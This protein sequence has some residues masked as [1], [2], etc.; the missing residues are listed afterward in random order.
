MHDVENRELGNMYKIKNEDDHDELPL[1]MANQLDTESNDTLS[2][3]ILLVLYILQGIPMGLA[4]S[5]PLLLKEKGASYES[6]SLFSL[7]SMP[8]S[9]KLVWA[10]IV[11]ST[12]LT[13][14]GRRKTW[15]IPVQLICGLIMIFGASHIDEWIGDNKSNHTGSMLNVELLTMFFMFLYFLMAT[16]DIAVDGWALT[17]LSRRNVGYGSVCNTIGQSLGAFI[18][19]QGFIALSDE[20]WCHRFLGV[21]QGTTFVTLS[22]F[23]K[24]WGIVFLVTTLVIWFF[25]SESPI[26]AGDEPE[27]LLTTYKQVVSI[28]K[29]KPVQLLCVI[30]L[31]RKITTTPIDAASTFKMQDYGMPKGDIA[32]ISPILMLV[33]FLVPTFL[34]N[35][36]ASK[37][38]TLLFIGC[39]LQLPASALSWAVVQTVPSAYANHQIPGLSFY[40]PLITV[41]VFYQVVSVMVFLAM[42][43]SFSKVADPG[44]GGTYMTL[45]NTVA[46]M[47]YLWTNSLCLW[48][49]PKLSLSHC[50]SISTGVKVILDNSTL[51]TACQHTTT[52]LCESLEGKCLEDIDSF[53]VMVFICLG[54]GTIWVLLF[55]EKIF[56]LQDMTHTE[57]WITSSKKL[58]PNDESAITAKKS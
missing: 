17:M 49:L 7:V 41:S 29:T 46:N 6:L 55:K 11:D 8:F 10:P 42:M 45:L 23:M 33:Q 27:G 1:K 34:G 50:Y 31:T 32:S 47:G 9:L 2:M 5:V 44:I 28:L 43:S 14:M 57:W 53:T 20:D 35:Y 58:S 39:V 12:F 19:N 51:S 16:Q 25:K 24:F 56:K 21:E 13:S 18:A 15:L 52:E 26:V 22:G 3:I 4:G 54:L 48:I 30:I 37:P 40:L 38:F 36:A